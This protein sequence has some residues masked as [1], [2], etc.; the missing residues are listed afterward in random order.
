[1]RMHCELLGSRFSEE[2]ITT[3]VSDLI[4]NM[5][6]GKAAYRAGALT[7]AL[8]NGRYTTP[9]RAPSLVVSSPWHEVEDCGINVDLVFV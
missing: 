2:T 4:K 1:M 6:G 5:V 3:S 9:V 8:R 7:L